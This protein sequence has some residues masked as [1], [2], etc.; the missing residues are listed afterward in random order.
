M[1]DHTL[2]SNNVTRNAT[3]EAIHQR[4]ADSGKVGL[5]PA[6]V[7]EATYVAAGVIT[8]GNAY[9][10]FVANKERILSDEG[11]FYPLVEHL[12]GRAMLMVMV[13]GK[14]TPADAV[15]AATDEWKA[16]IRPQYDYRTDTYSMDA[17][18]DKLK[19]DAED[20]GST[21]FATEDV[22]PWDVDGED[23]LGDRAVAALE[24]LT[25]LQREAFEMHVSGHGPTEIARVLGMK[26]RANANALVKRAQNKLREVLA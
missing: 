9:P 11:G 21:W 14:L 1:S 23:E 10:W 15:F 6:W 3:L 25:P 5:A 13:D 20:Q 26:D 16:E 17:M 19:D 22:H 24:V 8:K 4:M 18:L 7:Q 2:V 12:V